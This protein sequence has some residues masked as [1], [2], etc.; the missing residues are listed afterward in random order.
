M[1]LKKLG[2]YLFSAGVLTSCAVTKDQK[3]D[4]VKNVMRVVMNPV[5]AHKDYP[6]TLYL[7]AGHTQ[8]SLEITHCVQYARAMYWD[9]VEG[10]EEITDKELK[11]R[12]RKI[13]R[14]VKA[15][16]RHLAYYQDFNE[17]SKRFEKC[18]KPS[19]QLNEKGIQL[20]C[21]N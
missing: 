8:D 2:L 10:K 3:N 16:A 18:E 12:N 7:S 21:G 17:N 20:T 13:V 5:D 6:E 11:K 1:S 14:A 9:V 4:A 15:S 19:L